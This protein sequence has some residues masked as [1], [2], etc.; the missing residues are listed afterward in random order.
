LED[1]GF[2]I[3]IR[4]A[5]IDFANSKYPLW[6]ANR[7][8][9][10]NLRD[11]IAPPFSGHPSVNPHADDIDYQIEA[12]YAGLIAPGMPHT[13]IY[14]GEKFGRIMNYGDGVYGG[15]FIGA[16]YA[17]AFFEKD[18]NKIVDAGLACIPPESQYAEAIRDVIQWHSEHPADWQATWQLV[19]NKY[20]LNPE[21]RQFSCNGADKDFNIDAKINGAYVVMGLLYGEGDLDKTIVVSM[22]CGMDSDCNPSNAAGIL[23]T[24]KGMKGLPSKYKTGIDLTTK[25]AF[26]SYD[27]PSLLKVCESLMKDAVERAG[28][29][30][31]ATGGSKEEIFIPKEEPT[32]LPLEQSWATVGINEEV[33]FGLEEMTR[34]KE[35]TREPEEH[36]TEWHVAG[37]FSIEGVGDGALLDIAFA[38]ELSGNYSKWDK[39]P[40]DMENIRFDGVDLFALFDQK[41]SIAYMKTE[42]WVDSSQTVLFEMGSDG[43][44]K[45]WLNGVVVHK[46]NVSRVYVQGQDVV[47][48]SLKKGW[49]KVLMKVGQG[50][51]DWAASLVVTDTSHTVLRNIK[52]KAD[53]GS[54]GI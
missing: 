15:I 19:E 30:I 41:P 18:V 9:R 20:N 21:Y 39:I 7:S 13:V 29:K 25:F 45:V 31:I 37:P 14:L 2:D 6:H 48:V 38:P 33:N 1:Y 52:V 43:D 44:L 22:R 26:T 10:E 12:D 42:I 46:K 11:G 28:G 23:A 50:M 3:S 27:F 51:M 47:E 34:I 54:P 24:S 16:M 4:Q 32:E 5:G 36:V 17:E 49:N 8:G 53:S 40:I 35:K